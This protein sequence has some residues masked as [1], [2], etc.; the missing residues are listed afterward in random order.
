M[1]IYFNLVSNH[2]KKELEDISEFI[3]QTEEQMNHMNEVIVENL[4]EDAKKMKNTLEHSH[5]DTLKRLSDNYLAIRE[6][7]SDISVS[8]IEIMDKIKEKSLENFLQLQQYYGN[9]FSEIVEGKFEI[10]ISSEYN[11]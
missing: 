1:I 8:K 4:M 7:L 2:T 10:K 9:A 3:E 11:F 5:N 6:N